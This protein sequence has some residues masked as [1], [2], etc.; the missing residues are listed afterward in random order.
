M[1]NPDLQKEKEL[2]AAEALK[3]VKNRMTIGL[4]TGSTAA[5]FVRLLA[6]KVRA[7]GWKIRCVATSRAAAKLAKGL[8]LKVI[9]FNT[10]EKV[11]VAVDGADEIDPKGNLTKGH[12][13]A[14]TREKLIDYRAEKFIVLGDSSK[15]KE[16]LGTTFIP[17]EV[18]PF[19]WKWVE[20]ELEKIGGNAERR[21]GFKTDNGNYIID[22]HAG[23]INNPEKI[24][25]E[26]G[27]IPGVLETGLFTKNR[28]MAIIGTENEVKTLKF[29]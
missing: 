1:Q 12:G 13:G 27:L 19:C 22:W 17:V 2:A 29:T 4:G 3:Y 6:E 8:G 15:L 24:E 7:E 5:V 20:R 10:A 26:I 9:E 16:H 14:L 21:K 23:A 18:M 11:D 28:H 25:A